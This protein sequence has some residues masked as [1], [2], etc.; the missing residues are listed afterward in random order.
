M[1]LV[2]STGQPC[3]GVRANALLTTRY[4]LITW[5][6]WNTN[7]VHRSCASMVHHSC[8]SMV[9]VASP[10]RS[11]A[12][13]PRPLSLPAALHEFRGCSAVVEGGPAVRCELNHTL[14][15]CAKHVCIC[16]WSMGLSECAQCGGGRVR[17]RPS[18]VWR[19]LSHT[20]CVR[21]CM[22]NRALCACMFERYR[23]GGHWRPVRT[24]QCGDGVRVVSRQ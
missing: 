4:L 6:T 7:R 16:E 2:G 22:C 9:R 15:T 23:C 13:L 19:M 20:L 18:G 3:W 8:A 17:G 1:C 12:G 5:Y 11:P 24:A 21:V 10:T 14:H